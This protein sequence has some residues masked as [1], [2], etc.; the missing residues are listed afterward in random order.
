MNQITIYNCICELY[1]FATFFQIYR[2]NEVLK[3]END[4][5]P[6]CHCAPRKAAFLQ[7]FLFLGW[8]NRKK[9]VFRF[10]SK[11]CFKATVITRFL[12]GSRIDRAGV[13]S[14]ELPVG[15]P[16]NDCFWS[17]F[18][19]EEEKKN[20]NWFKI[21]FPPKLGHTDAQEMEL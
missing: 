3:E 2:Q 7:T 8:K 20:E 9:L 15:R 11:S 1:I 17:N 18:Q 10:R 5:A 16:W 13:G 12:L 4:F 19:V 6:S 14:R 21:R